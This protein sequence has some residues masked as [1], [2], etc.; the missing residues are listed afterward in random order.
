MKVSYDEYES[1]KKYR[2]LDDHG[3]ELVNFT[4]DKETERIENTV[5][6]ARFPVLLLLFQCG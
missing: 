5:S 3:K 4:L 6:L 1:I 2:N